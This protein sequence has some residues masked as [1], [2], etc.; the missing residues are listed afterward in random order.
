VLSVRA[1]RA[2]ATYGYLWARRRVGG[3]KAIS[4]MLRVKDEAEFL[5]PAVQSIA[6]FVDEIVLVDNLSRDATPQIIEALAAER[7]HQIV[8]YRYPYEVRKVGVDNLDLATDAMGL[9]SP[10]LSSMFYNW[11]LARC[12]KPY[13]L[14]WDG[15][16][17]AL[18][19]LGAAIDAW[20]RSDVQVLVLNGANVHPDFE[21]L[22]GAVESNWEALAAP[23]SSRLPKWAATLNYDYPEPRLFPKRCTRYEIVPG[24]TQKLQTPFL[25]PPLAPN[26]IERIEGVSFAHMK[27]CKR[28]PFATYSDDLQRAIAANLSVGPPLP[29]AVVQVLMRYRPTR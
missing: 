14:K 19:Q 28:D 3:H 23:L 17:I 7:P 2:Y 9:R 21:H 1:W 6:D 29:E 16:M 22:V 8:C 25:E 27:F 4:V 18:P 13:V 5:Y 11:C 12:S 15:D 26:C 24:F 10:H 20:R